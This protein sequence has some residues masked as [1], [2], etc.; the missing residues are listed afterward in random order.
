MTQQ[1]CPLC[2]RPSSISANLALFM[3]FSKLEL[4]SIPLCLPH[5]PSIQ[6]F[7]SL[8]FSCLVANVR[9]IVKKM[10][11]K[12]DI[13]KPEQSKVSAI[14]CSEYF[15][16]RVQLR[17]YQFSLKE[18]VPIKTRIAITMRT[19]NDEAMHKYH[20]AMHV[21]RMPIYLIL[22]LLFYISPWIKEI[23]WTFKKQFTEFNF[24]KY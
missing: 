10:W 6:F 11:H 20:V 3:A 9:S 12:D 15:F 24:H 7:S 19:M 16:I 21:S 4:Y 22:L 23:D 14:E 13:L 8:A 1:I 17:V 2:V 18:K 5:I